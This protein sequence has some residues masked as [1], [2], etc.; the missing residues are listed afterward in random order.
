M[1]DQGLTP[2]LMLG[3]YAVG[4]FPMAADAEDEDLQ[5]YD[6]D[7]RG[8][9][10]LQAFH[11]PRRLRRTVLSGRFD[12]TVDQDFP[13]VMKGCAAPAPG[14]EQTWIN[15]EIYRLFC[16]LHEMGY[17]HSVECRQNGE[18]VGGL[19]GVALGGA[20]FGESMFSRVTDA[21]KVALVHLVARLRLSGFMVLDTQFGTDHLTRFGGVEI[22]AAE[23]KTTLER[24]VHMPPCWQANFTPQQL[25]AEIRTMRQGS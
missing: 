19:Y 3:A 22:P 4:L 10:P 8:V 6:P 9:L 21:S 18:L 1:S 12:V 13:A 7:P 17:A 24:A 14:R 16:A 20:F 2:E 5:W 11:L 15:S 23:Y 25:E